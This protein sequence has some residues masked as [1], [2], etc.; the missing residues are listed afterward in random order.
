MGYGIE[1]YKSDLVIKE[2]N[3]FKAMRAL[4]GKRF[5]FCSRL[6]APIEGD[7]D[8]Y[9]IIEFFE[10]LRYEID[11]DF[12]RQRFAFIDFLGEKYGA[13]DEIFETIAPY[14]ED[15]QIMFRGEDGTLIKLMVK[16]GR[17]SYGETRVGGEL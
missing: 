17:F 15:G 8:D 16:N 14:C 6:N 9:E 5:P 3:I 1:F 13:E 12:K 10:G 7:Y 2:E 11:D 4:E